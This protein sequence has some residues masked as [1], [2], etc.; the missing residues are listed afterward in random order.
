[1]LV[2]TI[3]RQRAHF[4]RKVVAPLCQGALGAARA[5]SASLHSSR[6]HFDDVRLVFDLP[7][8]EELEVHAKVG[9]NLLEIAQ[10]NDIDDIEGACE[11]TCCC[12][13]CHVVLE[14]DVYDELGEVYEEEMDMLDLAVG[15]KD[16]SRL[17]CQVK[18]TKAM[19]GARI[20]IPDEYNNMM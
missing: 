16:T 20:T 1:M 17:G 10:D 3:L 5:P 11:G 6:T 4:A 14:K 9:D 12:S 2:R 13:T 18:V 15:L 7:G 8:G 19:D